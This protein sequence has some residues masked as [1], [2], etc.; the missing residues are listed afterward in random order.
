MEYSE[1]N[2][3]INKKKRIKLQNILIKKFN[4]PVITLRI[5]CPGENK[6]NDIMNN[7]VGNMDEVIS[8]I[9]S[10]HIHFKML[11]ITAEGPIMNFVINREPKE[12]KKITIEIEDKHILGA[13]IDIDVYDSNMKKISRTDFGIEE[14]RC[15]LCNDIAAKCIQE[16]KHSDAEIRRYIIRKYREYKESFYE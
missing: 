3:L 2:I 10:A 6:Y 8:D 11:R 5:V 14:R 13:C 12:V 15:F 7:I 4:M 9:F 1:E 16:K